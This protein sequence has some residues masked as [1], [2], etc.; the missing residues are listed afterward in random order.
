V[1]V[2]VTG[3]P[4]IDTPVAAQL[5]RTFRSVGLLGARVIVTGVS[6][7]LAQSLVGLGVDFAGLDSYADLQSGVES[8]R[9]QG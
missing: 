7:E 2:D 9:G 1:V 5:Q 6:G 8:A 3:V 4:D